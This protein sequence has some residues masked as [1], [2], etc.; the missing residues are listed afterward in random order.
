MRAGRPL[1]FEPLPECS[2]CVSREDALAPGIGFDLADSYGTAAIRYH[3]LSI[4]NL[5]KVQNGL[6]NVAKA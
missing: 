5:G 2:K 4:V 6:L 3:N 1:R